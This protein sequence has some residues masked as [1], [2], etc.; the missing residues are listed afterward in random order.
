[1][2]ECE[3]KGTESGARLRVFMLICD[4]LLAAFSAATLAHREWQ[5]ER[6]K[7][8]RQGRQEGEGRLGCPAKAISLSFS[9]FHGNSHSVCLRETE[10]A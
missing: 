9:L 8:A 6:E 7:E 10:L 3:A 1:M 5:L 4:P 2:R